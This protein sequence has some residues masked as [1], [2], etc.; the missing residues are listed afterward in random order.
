MKGFKRE[1]A[2]D[3]LGAFL[4]L[5]GFAAVVDVEGEPVRAVVDDPVRGARDLDVGLPSDGIRL[6]ARTADLPRRREP[7]EALVVGR[8]AYIIESWREDLGVSEVSLVKAG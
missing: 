1:V 6:F 2:R 3:V 5:D 4:D 7:G 8:R